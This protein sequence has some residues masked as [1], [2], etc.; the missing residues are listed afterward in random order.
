MKAC[1]LIIC[2]FYTCYSYSQDNLLLAENYFRQGEYEKASHIYKSLFEKNTFNADY[3]KKLVTCYQETRQFQL[4]ETLLRTLLK[5]HVTRK[6]LH[7]ELGYNYERQQQ[8]ELANVEYRKALDYISTNPYSAGIIGRTFQQNNAL[9][10]A[11]LAY[12]KAMQLNPNS[13]YQFQIAQIFGEKGAFEKMFEAY[14]NLV[15]SNERYIR[16]VQR[17]ISGYISDD[18]LDKNNIALKKSLLRKSISNPKNIWNELLSWLFS[19]QKEYN[20]AFVQ[21][22]ALFKRDVMYLDNISRLGKIA[23]EN[24]DYSTAKECFSFTLENTSFIDERINSELFLLKV[25]IAKED[26]NILQLFDVALETYGINANTIVIQMEYANFL[27]FKKGQPKKSEAILERA[28][29]YSRSKFQ[30]AQIKLKLGEIFVFTS[31]FNKALIYFSQVQTSLKNHPLSQEAR[32]KVAQTSYFKGDFPWAMAQ[33]KVLKGSTTQLT[34]NDAVDLFLIISDNQPRDS[35]PSGLKQYAKADLL[36]YQNKY[37]QA[38]TIL[39]RICQKFKGFPVEDEAFFKQ[40]KIMIHLKR[41]EDAV[42]AFKKVIDLDPE[43]ILNDDAIFEIAELY[44]NNLNLPEKAKEYYQ[45]IIF[46]YPSSF[47][48]VDVRRKYRELWGDTVQQ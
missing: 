25:A 39:E 18:P 19:K 9:D 28:L 11:I 26:K 14:I 46:D 16:S 29:Q 5:E 43:G 20:K 21:E 37:I 24:R 33:L 22:K 1:I 15:D 30:R 13:N 23:F 17:L 40:A 12:T 48:L 38:L 31:Q 6:Y 35:I 7:V 32:F 47:Y 45:K 2:L 42:T 44:R 4:A 10:R 27:T 34:A 36:S 3:L 8:I 41:H